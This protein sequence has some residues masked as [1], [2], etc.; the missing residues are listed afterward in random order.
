MPLYANALNLIR[1][2]LE[3][4]AKGQKPPLI[5][6]GELSAD[7][8]ATVNAQ[9]LEEDLLPVVSQVLFDGRHLFNS[10]CVEDGYTIDDVLAQISSAFNDASAVSP[11]W[12][13]V[14]ISR[15]PR[16]DRSGRVIRDEAVF[17]CHGRLPH[18]ELLSVVPRGDGKDHS[19]KKK[20]TR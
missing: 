5:R 4:A 7:Q 10:R 9:R 16:I 18:P 12:S 11:G 3:I 2:N 15:I 14:L 8:L 19:K 13:T 20:A 17:E 1:A 6:I